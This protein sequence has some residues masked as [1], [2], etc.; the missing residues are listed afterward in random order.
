MQ[1]RLY[2]LWLCLRPD[3]HVCALAASFH[4]LLHV[5]EALCPDGIACLS[6]MHTLH[7]VL[8][9]Y[10]TVLVLQS[11]H[12]LSGSTWRKPAVSV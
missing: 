3:W 4:M 2:G 6:A 5:L 1:W 11:M 8:R 10:I 9:S 7:A 12:M